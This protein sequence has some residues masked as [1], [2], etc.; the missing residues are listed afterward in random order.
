MTN[1]A[2]HLQYIGAHLVWFD[3]EPVL[4]AEPPQ[5]VIN[6]SARSV[7]IGNVPLGCTVKSKAKIPAPP[8]MERAP[9]T[10]DTIAEVNKALRE[11]PPFL[12][13]FCR[14]VLEPVACSECGGRG[15]VVWTNPD[16]EAEYDPW[17]TEECPRCNGTG[18][19]PTC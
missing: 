12:H 17:D 4:L 8:G 2:P 6:E 5:V 16:P 9:M 11:Q 14:C 10:R 13:A 19:E 7:S 3:G 15:E 1:N 18:K